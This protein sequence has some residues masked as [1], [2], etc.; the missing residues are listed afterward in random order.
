MFAITIKYVAILVH[1]SCLPVVLTVITYS[2]LIMHRHEEDI[3]LDVRHGYVHTWKTH[4]RYG[5]IKTSDSHEK[6]FCHMHC[7]LDGQTELC[8]GEHVIFIR[9]PRK[10]K[11]QATSVRVVD[12]PR[13]KAMPVPKGVQRDAKTLLPSMPVATGHGGVQRN[14]ETS[15][16]AMP[17][18]TCLGDVRS[19]AE[20]SS[21]AMPVAT[22]P[23]G[24]RGNVATWTSLPAEGNASACSGGLPI[25]GAGPIPKLEMQPAMQILI[26]SS[27][28]ESEA[29]QT[30]FVCS[31]CDQPKQE[32]MYW[33]RYDCME[34]M[35]YWGSLDMSYR[36]HWWSQE[37][38]STFIGMA[39]VARNCGT[40]SIVERADRKMNG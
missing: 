31:S 7:L 2:T 21:P 12:W 39:S 1:S 16:P 6:L 3:F 19:I 24:V 17:V 26:S 11:F 15:L 38:A 28:S 33:R 29:M 5:F 13:A 4:R 8:P 10:G 25:C 32:W 30:T 40:S 18:A 27:S 20:T 35:D 37:S 9:T 14:A 36:I 22:G 34:S 23:G